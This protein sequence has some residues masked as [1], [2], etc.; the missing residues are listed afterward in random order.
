MYKTRNSLP[1]NV[2]GQAIGLL[3]RN[4]ALAIDLKLQTKQ[5][6]WN[7]KGPNFIALHE[8][9]DSIATLA[10]GFVDTIAERITSLGGT[11]E[12]T[13]QAVAKNSTLPAYP[14]NITT[15]NAHID[16]LSGALAAFGA[17][18]RKAI[19]EFRRFRRRRH[20][21]RL[22][23]GEP[24]GRQ[25]ALVPRGAYPGLRSGA[26]ALAPLIRPSA[27]DNL[28]GGGADVVSRH[29]SLRGP[30]RPAGACA[31]RRRHSAA[32]AG[33][34][35]LRQ[36]RR[37]GAGAGA[38]GAGN[39][40]EYVPLV[41]ILMGLLEAQRTSLYLLHALGIALIVGRVLHAWGL[42]RSSGRSFGRAAGM[43]SPGPCWWWLRWRRWSWI[44]PALNFLFG[45]ISYAEPASFDGEC[46]ALS[47]ARSR[48]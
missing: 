17:S 47:P 19:D 24:R 30:Q 40:A 1:E 10:D 2:R 35:P 3:S 16:A 4:L 28:G 33:A 9:F 26:A 15:G 5:A 43:A 46:Q 39:W 7:V 45:R 34:R 31:G 11:A 18:V 29:N 38:A 13:L 22:H 44:G 37:R 25:A 14:L 42:S 48:S 36:W 8:L 32:H 21:R 23:R 27:A 12:G 41:L 20:R 6:H